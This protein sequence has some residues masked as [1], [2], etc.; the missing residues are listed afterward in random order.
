MEGRGNH[1]DTQ[2]TIEEFIE[3]A[4]PKTA[5]KPYITTFRKSTQWLWLVGSDALALS[6]AGFLAIQLRL[7]LI[8]RPLNLSFYYSIVLVII[9][10]LLVFYAVQ[11]LYPGTGISPPNEIRIITLTTSGGM[12]LIAIYL[13]VFQRGL[14]FSRSVY[15]LFWVL[16]LFFVPTMRLLAKRIGSIIKVWGEP[17]AIIGHGENIARLLQHLRI[18]R[19][20]GYVPVLLIDFNDRITTGLPQEENLPTIHGDSLLEH[21]T[22]LKHMGINTAFIIQNNLPK[23]F[24]ELFLYEEVFNLRHP[25]VISD[26]GNI[27]GSAIMPYDLQGVLGLEVQRNLFMRRY[28]VMKRVI[29]VFL[30]ITS[31][32]IVLPL[33]MIL[34]ILIRLDSPGNIFYTQTRLGYLGQPFK[35]FKFRT[36]VKEADKALTEY[37]IHN[38]DAKAEWEQGHKL[39]YDPR[40]TRIGRFLRQSSLDELPQLW[41][42]LKGEMSLVGPRPIVEDEVEYYAQSYRTYKKV[43]PGMTGLWQVSGRSDTSYENRVNLDEYYVRHWS[44]WLDF[45]ILMRT[46]WAVISQRGAY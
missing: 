46:L 12:A 29:N 15:L 32:P 44:V 8:P 9:V 34:G 10:L 38:P 20:Y 5:H 39:K 35:L 37:F 41:N 33:G 28:R 40:V 24:Q 11:R 19:L 25:I 6:L 43:K 17:V 14:L 7:L 3:G 21:K 4:A 1:L 45:Y 30:T 42:V 31:L 16:A 23:T 26:L 36:M 27:G 13:F 18:H 22:L 2:S